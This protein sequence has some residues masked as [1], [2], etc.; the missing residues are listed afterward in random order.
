MPI[1]PLTDAE[2]R[3]RLLD[4]IHTVRSRQG[5]VFSALVIPDLAASSLADMSTTLSFTAPHAARGQDGCMDPGL[6][7]AMM[8]N[9]LGM[10]AISQMG[11]GSFTPTVDLHISYYEGIPVDVPL[12]IDVKKER[13]TSRCIFLSG[14]IS[15][16]DT[17]DVT[18]AIAT[19]S[20]YITR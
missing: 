20:F 1:L 2:L 12:R 5:S 11:D 17:P 10:L 8:D 15:R 4:H 16:E 7:A 6:V 19:G 13:Q 14:R 9:S 3:A 18:L